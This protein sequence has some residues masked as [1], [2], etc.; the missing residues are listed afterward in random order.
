MTSVLTGV[1]A[2]PVFAEVDFLA[3][4]VADAEVD[5]LEELTDIKADEM[6]L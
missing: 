6:R 5:L 3:A 1:R 4:V 2:L